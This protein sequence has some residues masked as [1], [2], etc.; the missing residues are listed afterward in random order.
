[1]KYPISYN[2][3]L[4]LTNEDSI[5]AMEYF[6]Q[7]DYYG[8]PTCNTFGA[9]QYN[10]DSEEF[11]VVAPDTIFQ[12]RKIVNRLESI[13]ERR[14]HYKS[15]VSSIKETKGRTT[16]SSCTRKCVPN[17]C[18]SDIDMRNDF[19]VFRKEDLRKQQHY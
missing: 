13:D 7:N 15:K 1:M 12:N 18:I 2:A 8:R 4:K 16:F 9:T 14:H 6:Y 10:D 11:P 5:S 17:C 3:I 19:L